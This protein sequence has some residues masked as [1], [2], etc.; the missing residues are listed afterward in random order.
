MDLGLGRVV[1]TALRR[2]RAQVRKE[3]RPLRAESSPT[4]APT[5]ALDRIALNNPPIGTVL[6]GGLNE[7]FHLLL[8]AVLGR[9]TDSHSWWWQLRDPRK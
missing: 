5:G 1:F 7:P 4:T 3:D 6:A 9:Y 8:W 2:G